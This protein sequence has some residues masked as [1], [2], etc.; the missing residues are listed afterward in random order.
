METELHD[1]DST[2]WGF[3]DV[4]PNIIIL[5]IVPCRSYTVVFQTQGTIYRD[6]DVSM[7]LVLVH[8]IANRLGGSL[9]ELETS[10]N[11][12]IESTAFLALLK[13]LHG[14]QVFLCPAVFGSK[15]KQ[16]KQI[17]TT[18]KIFYRVMSCCLIFIP[19]A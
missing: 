15:I 4:C 12:D 1:I 16:I 3:L 2:L 10:V 6:R 5:R 18:R 9:R 19:F 17:G 13:G 8:N 7:P 11:V 14:L